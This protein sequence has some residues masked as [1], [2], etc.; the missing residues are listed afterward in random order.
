MQ[1]IKDLA[2]GTPEAIQDLP[3]DTT[4]TTTEVPPH[5]SNIQSKHTVV[6]SK[7]CTILVI[8]IHVFLLVIT[9]QNI[10]L[11]LL[12]VTF[13]YCRNPQYTRT[14]KIFRSNINSNLRFTKIQKIFLRFYNKI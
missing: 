13:I 14:K 5:V 4:V 10:D 11:T 12:F 2:S 6:N 3:L 9:I 7:L 1:A 8:P